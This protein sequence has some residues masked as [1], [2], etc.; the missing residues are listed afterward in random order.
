MT[1][2]RKIF[3]ASGIWVLFACFTVPA[4]AVTFG[5]KDN[6]ATNQIG[7]FEGWSES[8]GDILVGCVGGT[9]TATGSIVPTADIT[10]TFPQTQITSRIINTS[11]PNTH[12][13][14]ISEATLIIDDIR[15]PTSNSASNF[16]GVRPHLVCNDAATPSTV[17]ECSV[18]APGPGGA[19]STIQGANT[20]DGSSGH[21]NVFVGHPSGSNAVVFP[22]VP[23]DPS[24]D[25]FQRTIRITNLR[26]NATVFDP[27]SPF[28]QLIATISFSGPASVGLTTIQTQVASVQKGMGAITVT[29]DSSFLQ[30]EYPTATLASADASVG[31]AETHG[32]T[33]AC[34]TPAACAGLASSQIT[35]DTSSSFAGNHP[36]IQITEGFQTSWKPRNMSELLGT[37]GEVLGIDANCAG[38]PSGFGSPCIGTSA[39]NNSLSNANIFAYNTTLPHNNRPISPKTVR[40]SATSRKAVSRK[41]QER[42]AIPR[43]QALASATWREPPEW[44]QAPWTTEPAFSSRSATSRMGRLSRCP[45]SWSSTTVISPPA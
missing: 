43:R 1:Q 35:V 32:W 7:R 11:D 3:C 15:D 10:V 23:L 28:A 44:A 41:S 36:V 26:F 13:T 8:A 39:D 38:G 20:Y 14:P 37:N 33:S 16:A 40:A 42:S 19:G 5:C 18:T 21:P 4:G 34:G 22:G 6:T 31:L 25:N 27:T 29:A 30:C 2:F 24:G 17:G 45:R 12:L 9:P